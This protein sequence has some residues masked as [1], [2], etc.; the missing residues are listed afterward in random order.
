MKHVN[1]TT[2]I[3]L[4]VRRLNNVIIRQGLS[5]WIKNKQTK[6]NPITCFL[7]KTHFRFEDPNRLR[8]K[9]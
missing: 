8:V 1:S 9:G 2:S 3:K 7:Q 4:N 5:D 6:Y